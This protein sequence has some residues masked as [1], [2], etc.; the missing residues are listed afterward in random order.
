MLPRPKTFLGIMSLMTGAELIALAL[1]FNKATGFYGILTLFTGYS[2]SAL[3][4]SAYILS[5]VALVVLGYTIP[6]IRKQ[7][8]FQNMI[9]AWLYV[10]DT[11]VN[12]AYT[13]VFAVTW[14]LANFHDPKGPAGAE[15]DHDSPSNGDVQLDPD[16]TKQAEAGLGVQESVFSLMLVV[17]LM[18]L[19]VYFSLVVLAYARSVV[20]RYVESHAGW[21]DEDSAKGISPD[22]FAVGSPLGEGLKGKL[23]RLMVSFGRGYWL[24]RKEDEEW[25]R[26]VG[27]R[28]GGRGRARP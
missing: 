21:A 5:L 7:S 6:H 12:I 9:L 25:A 20:Q 10:L 27:S 24:G 2:M 11:L 19:R 4:I 26:D 18:L 1:V 17:A 16:Q 23:G 15:D 3:Q 28:F 14:Y 13:I 22:P 8:P